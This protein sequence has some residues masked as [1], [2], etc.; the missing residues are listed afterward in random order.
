MIAPI[1]SCDLQPLSVY[2]LVGCSFLGGTAVDIWRAAK[3]MLSRG[4][5]AEA[6]SAKRVDELAEDGDHAGVAVWKRMINA[7]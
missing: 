1:P 7:I 6:E 3:L 4:D 5:N 2:R